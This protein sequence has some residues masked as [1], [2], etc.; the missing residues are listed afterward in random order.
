MKVSIS[1]KIAELPQE[2]KDK[3]IKAQKAKNPDADWD[4]ALK[5]AESLLKKG[6]EPSKI[7]SKGKKD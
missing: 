1:T 4:S 5:K 3:W 2:E 6:N 7:S